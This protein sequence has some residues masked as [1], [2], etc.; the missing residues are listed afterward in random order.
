MATMNYSED[1]LRAAA[2]AGVVKTE[3]LSRL[4]AFLNQRQAATPATDAVSVSRFDVVHVLWYAGALIVIGAMGLFS[5]L[6]FSKMGGLAITI[7]AVVYALIFTVC[8]HYLWYKRNLPTPGGLLITVAVCMAP[9]AVFGIQD[10]LG[11]WGSF[12]EPGTL[13]DFYVW[14]KG[15]WLFMEIAAV[16]A[17]ILALTFYRFPF[18]TSAIAV[19]LWFMSMDLTPWIFGTSN[20]DWD[21]RRRVSLWFGLGMIVVAWILDLRARGRDFAFWLHL[22]G[23]MAFWGALTASESFSE[24]NNALYCLLNVGLLYVAIFLMRRA[25]AVFGGLGIS[26]Y[27]GHLAGV[28]FKDSLL[29][30]FALSAIGIAVIVVGLIY[31]RRQEALA[32]W[33]TAH[34]P[35]AITRLRPARP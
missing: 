2:A 24:I 7:T 1:D 33:L 30:P 13:H 18:I 16:L 25:Y 15:S 28:V 8:G 3:E 10:E 20:F 22:F 29:F 27:L 35:N 34:L 5:T 32:R 14:V 31:H 23:L 19:A 21:M 12:G 4:I 17:G 9:L 26:L 6:A 11:W